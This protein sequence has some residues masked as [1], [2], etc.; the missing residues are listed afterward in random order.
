MNI[1]FWKVTLP[2]RDAREQK[3]HM[4]SAMD[5]K[6]YLTKSTPGKEAEN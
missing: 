3:M 1:F 2:A 4:L 5:M 6:D